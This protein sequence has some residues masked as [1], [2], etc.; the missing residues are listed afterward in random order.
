L[1]TIRRFDLQRIIKEYKTVHFFET[2]TFRGDG[3]SFAL[4]FPFKQ[5]TSVEIVSEIAAQAKS[6]FANNTT[7]KIIAADSVTALKNELPHL[8]NNCVFWLDAHFPGAD[9]GMTAYDTENNEEVR[10]PLVKELETI[11]VLRNE[12]NDVLILDDLRIYE[13]GPYQNG[14]VPLDALPK[15][16]R[17][18]QFVYKYF[19]STHVII[20]CYLD[21]GYIL[22]FPKK[23]Y[24]KN[25]RRFLEFLRETVVE[26]CYLVSS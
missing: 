14:N 18:I 4:N 20:K 23:P 22:L 8:Q 13:D 24:K 7:V 1:G 17:S 12:F 16:E 6:K 26:D 25:H 19:D 21:E 9:A 3:V 10:L 2:G 11:S 5:I 15:M